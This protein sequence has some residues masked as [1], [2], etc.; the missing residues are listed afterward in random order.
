MYTASGKRRQNR[1]NSSLSTPVERLHDHVTSS[2][3]LRLD[4]WKACHATTKE[5]KLLPQEAD[6]IMPTVTRT[7]VTA[8]CFPYGG[9]TSKNFA[10]LGK[11][12]TL[13]TDVSCSRQNTAPTICVFL[14]QTDRTQIYSGKNISY[15]RRVIRAPLS[16]AT[17][18]PQR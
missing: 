12:K 2:Y 9:T 8:R 1:Q 6:N 3:V 16:N 15:M 18:S 13:S 14:L 7:D 5:K 11:V 17:G 4:S 10:L